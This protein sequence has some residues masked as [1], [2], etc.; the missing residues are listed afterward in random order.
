MKM[1]DDVLHTCS[2]LKTICVPFEELQ[3]EFDFHLC[4]VSP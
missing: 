1:V 2:K 3:A 4:W